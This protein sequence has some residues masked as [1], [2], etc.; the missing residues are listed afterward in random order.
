MSLVDFDKI[1]QEE[2][3]AK[4]KFQN[5]FEEVYK[6]EL[7][8]LINDYPDTRSIDIDFKKL[9]E[10]DFELADSLLEDP[11][12]IIQ[13][14]EEA[15]ASSN[16]ALFESKKDFQIHVRFFN[17]PK[18]R[19]IPIRDISSNHLNK[20][21]SVEGIAREITEVFPS[22]RIASFKC[23]RCGSIQKLPQ[24]TQE[25]KLNSPVIC[26]ECNAREYILDQDNSIFE[27]YQK[28]NIQEPLERLKGNEQPVSLELHTRDDLVNK[29][30]IGNIVIYTGIL[31]LT[32]NNKS[33]NKVVYRKVLEIVHIEET[34]KEFEEV[35]VSKEEEQEIKEL[36]KRPDI[37]ERLIQSIAP[38]IYGH[39]DIKEAIVFQLFGGVRKELPGEQLIRGN[40]HILL[41]GDPGVAKSQL[42]QA[43]NRIAP[44][45]I[46]IAGKTTTSVGLTAS[47]V[48]ED[49]GE[50]AWSLKAGALVLASGGI[51]MTDELD[52]MTDEDRSA[53]HEAMEQGTVSVAKAGIVSRFKAD[54]SILSAANPKYSRFDRNSPFVDQV[55][56][57][58]SLVSRYDLFFMILDN[59]DSERDRNIANTIFHSHRL[60]E[61]IKQYKKKGKHLEMEEGEVKIKPLIEQEILRKYL[62]YSRQNIFP[63]LSEEAVKEIREFYLDL[64]RKSAQGEGAPPTHRQLEG[65]IRLAEASARVKLKDTADLEDAQRALKI[66]KKSIENALTDLKTGQPDFDLVNVGTPKT[67]TDLIR[68]VLRIIKT[69][70]REQDAV[71]LEEI[72]AELESRKMES[73]DLSD[74]LA[75]L[76]RA[77]DIY[78][79]KHGTWRPSDSN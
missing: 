67:K 32:P 75:S 45:S 47:A 21:I 6:K 22:L 12:T 13:A 57:A 17:L 16:L 76:S 23:R 31:R 7:D 73:S 74:I 8:A 62:A 68:E 34:H 42:L 70:A 60:G 69:K 3:P 40:I 77:G 20:L 56:L 38:A 1:E 61:K 65:L 59:Q 41:M 10:H 66:F 4:A 24:K 11:D 25:Q 14:A 36:S 50:G 63:I 48:K 43:A 15:I 39:D 28:I 27:D 53:L 33:P 72:K 19:Q 37:Y 49:F 44:K 52:K 9:G 26:S 51:C 64:R 2:N 79:P 58:K 71:T 54:T 18:D 35:E 5:F 55:N 30:S 78:S 46:Y 29:V